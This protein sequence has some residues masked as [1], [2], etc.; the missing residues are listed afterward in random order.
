MQLR[1]VPGEEGAVCKFRA[2]L[3][4][5]VSNLEEE[6]AGEGD[7]KGKRKQ[8]KKGREDM[9][10][11]ERKTYFEKWNTKSL[12]SSLC[13]IFV[14]AYIKL[15]KAISFPELFLKKEKLG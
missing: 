14:H 8:R 3:N 11:E 1:F 15:M 5:A 4:L 13:I 6:E 9:E 10:K 2:Q 7:W 12:K